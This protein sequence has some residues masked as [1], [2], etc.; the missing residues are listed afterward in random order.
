MDML[1]GA[2]IGSGNMGRHHVRIMSQCEDVELAYVVDSN[3]TTARELCGQWG[4]EA[5]PSINELSPIDVAIIAVPT[6]LHEEIALTLI[7]RGIN[8]L[9]EKPLADSPEAAQR[10]V[11]AAQEAGVTLAIGHVERFNPAIQELKRRLKSPK[12]I[13]IERLSPFPTRIK[14]SVIYDLTV[15]DVDL[16]CWLAESEPVDVHAMGTK[17]LSDKVDIASTQ[18]RFANGCIATLQTSRITQDKVRRIEISETERFFNVDMLKQNIE[19]KRSARVE[20]KTEEGRATFT[21]ETISEIPTIAAGGEPLRK[22]QE[23]FYRAVRSG[24]D[25]AVTGADGLRA[26][27]LVDQIEKLAT[28]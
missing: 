2:V 23:D 15:H 1:R 12:M 9:I 10:I 25:P 16:A 17:V 18:L 13:S 27:K 21:Q 11:D 26:V 5:L 6:Q 20:N 24:G 3:V 4:G 8:L 19:I 7:D 28:A 14:D 22:E